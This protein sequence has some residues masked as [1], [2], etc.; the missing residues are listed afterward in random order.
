MRSRIVSV[1][2]RGFRAFGTEPTQFDFDAPITIIHAGN[3]QGKTSL[4]E[5]LEFLISGRSSRRDLLGGAKAEYH[6]SLRNAHMPDGDDCVYIEAEVRTEDGE[7]HQVRRELVCDFGP[8]VEC[9]SRLIVDGQPAVDLASVGIPLADPPVRAPV[10]L[11]HI[12]RHAL[13]TEPKQRVGYFKALLS[14]MDLDGFRKHVA[15]VR[16]D[17]EREPPGSLLTLVDGLDATPATKAGATLKSLADTTEDVV[18]LRRRVETALLDAGAA[19]VQ[20]R[21]ATLHELAEAVKTTVEGQRERAFPLAAFAASGPTPAPPAPPMTAAYE[22][23]LSEAD[24]AAARVA[25]VLTAVLAID[26]F[27]SLDHPVDCPV[28][29]SNSALTPERLVELRKQ[30]DLTHAV[31]SAS[32]G[33]AQLINET[34]HT[35]DRAVSDARRVVPPAAAWPDEQM[36]AA[37]SQLSE[38]GVAPDVAAAARES[39]QQVATASATVQAAAAAVL[40]QID[41]AAEA[42]SGR[43]ALPD[44]DGA[45]ADLEAAMKELATCAARHSI[46]FE[47]LRT[48]VEPAIRERVTTSGLRELEALLDRRD[49]LVDDLAAESSRRRTVK[50]LKAAERALRDSAGR[51]LDDRFATMSDAIG[52]WWTSIRPEE[53]VGF[54]GVKRR[55][56]GERFVN[57]IAA[58]RADPAGSVIERDALGVYSDSQLNAL[59]LS[60]FLARA[61]LLGTPLVVLDDPIPGSDPEHRLTFVQNTLGQLLDAGIQV[62]LTTFDSKLADW[63]Q[64]NHDWRG[65]IAYE[66]TLNDRVAG[67]EATQTSDTFSRFLLEA[68]ENVN[69]P[70]ARGRRAACGSYRAAAERL[71]KQIIATGR[72]NEGDPC[73]VGDVEASVLG[74]LVPLV[75]G[76]ALDNAERGQWRTFAKVLN[77]G[78]HDDDVPSNIE[79]KQVRGNLRQ[80]N[81]AHRKHWSGGLQL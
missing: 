51:V 19:I 16:E 48:A 33:T 6:D 25:P 45:Y 73:S 42:V 23:A 55:A 64:S 21:S 50:R 44:M 29:G 43:Q 66:L 52:N 22:T 30:L 70:S 54:G 68:E 81:K 59:G 53:L 72:T 12:V 80:I 9:D 78:N 63:T 62:V 47:E 31:D 36:A 41:R 56:G 49:Q 26:E 75:S 69:A 7:A 17:L 24:Q 71:A 79:L 74:D 20:S 67:T 28:C 35:L 2:V 10:L 61:E 37:S 32:A 40:K 65:L 4:A 27:A 57:L 14:L 34:R 60:I 18:E 8:G 1:E 3:S 77:P 76:Y 15:S 39:A 11:Q 46:R 58:L 13:S 38:L 5:A